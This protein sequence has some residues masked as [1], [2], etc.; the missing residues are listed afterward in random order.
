MRWADKQ[1]DKLLLALVPKRKRRYVIRIRN[2]H[3]KLI[4]PGVSYLTR[5]TEKEA[6]E[7]ADAYNN[8][9]IRLTRG[10]TAHIQ[11]VV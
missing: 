6:Q 3:G 5:F 10:C 9:P 1:L 11:R 2:S 4:E 7:M 8:Y